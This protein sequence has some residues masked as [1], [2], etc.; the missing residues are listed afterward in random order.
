MRKVPVAYPFLFAL[1]P[2]LKLQSDIIDQAHI[3]TAL[4]AAVL[5]L[6]FALTLMM[7]FRLAVKD[8]D[9]AG[10]ISLVVLACAV[11]YGI[12]Y[13]GIRSLFAGASAVLCHAVELGL[14]IGLCYFTMRYVVTTRR[15]IGQARPVLNVAMVALI[16]MPLYSIGQAEYQLAR[17]CHQKLQVQ[18]PSEPGSYSVREGKPDVY[19][20]ILDGYGRADV[21]EEIYGYD[22]RDLCAFL[23]RKGFFLAQR[24]QSNY[25]QSALSLASSLNMTYLDFLTEELG[26][27]SSDRMPLTRLVQKSAV[28]RFLE[29]Q[30]YSVIAFSSGW[31]PTDW[32]DATYYW[33]LRDRSMTLLENRVLFL[34]SPLLILDDLSPALS[35]SFREIGYEGHRS[36]IRFA[37]DRLPY[38][39]QVAGPKLVFAHVV[40]PHPP[41]VFHADGQPRTPGYHYALADGTDFARSGEDYV[42]GYRAQVEYLDRLVPDV[43]SRILE[44][45]KEAPIIIIQ[46]D[47]GPGSGLVWDSIQETDLR[48]RF[49][50]L[51]AYYL[52]DGTSQLYDTITPVN[53]F[54]VV[55]NEYFGTS[56]PL[57]PDESWMSTWAHP[58]AFVRVPA[59]D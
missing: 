46:A 31:R 19:Y 12:I 4:R 11:E 5:V 36:R 44:A 40:C 23:Q 22:N 49:S 45:S 56:L 9:R 33:G 17:T 52:P 10:V 1:C 2:I 54:R 58:Y 59:G 15:D 50:I 55:L 6:I 24:S 37:L 38:A 35:L 21:L 3:S 34:F 16:A 48:E 51:N 27:D 42:S 39:A 28:R 20:I 26:S 25:G 29:D 13:P 7:A 53:S 41:F 32:A 8:C 43:I 30:G 47:H 18:L 14:W 57:L